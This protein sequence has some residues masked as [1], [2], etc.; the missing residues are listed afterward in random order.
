M[1]NRYLYDIL[2]YFRTSYYEI[3][4]ESSET[5]FKTD[6]FRNFFPLVIID[7]S[8]QNESVKS[9]T[10][11]AIRIWIWHFIESRAGATTVARI[12][13]IDKYHQ[14]KYHSHWMQRYHGA[15]SNDK[16]VHTIHE[17][18]RSVSPEYKISERSTPSDHLSSDHRTEHYGSNN[19][20]CGS[21]R[22]IAR[23]SRRRNH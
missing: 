2:V 9:G 6:S 20:R 7:C 11:D 17:F 19:S 21:R 5:L 14:R 16:S 3:S 13:C 8:R 15:Y 10:V 12:K 22:T 18:S 1:Q 4:K 23:F